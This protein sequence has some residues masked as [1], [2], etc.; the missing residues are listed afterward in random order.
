MG[1][2]TIGERALYWLR[3]RNRE[4]PTSEYREGMRRYDRSPRL[5]RVSVASWGGTVT[6][7]HA[8]QVTHELL[9][10]SDGSA[11][12]RIQL[13]FTPVLERASGEALIVQVEGEPPEIWTEVADLADSGP[14]DRHYTLD[15]VSGELR[16]GPAVRQP[17]G[18]IRV[19]GAVP[20]R[21]ANLIYER[22]RYGGGQVGNVEAN[23]LNTLKTAIPYIARVSNRQPARGGLDAESLEAAMMRTPAL[24]RSRD[25]AV[26]ESDFE[27]LARQALPGAI[28]RGKCLH[29]HPSDARTVAPGQVYVLV[30]PRI[31]RAGGYL[32]PDRLELRDADIQAL[33]AYLDARRLLT[34]RLDIRPPAYH[35]AVVKVRLRAAPGA[36]PANVEAQVLARLYGFLNPLTGGPDGDGW[37]FGRSLYV[38]D[39]YQCL[40]GIPDVQFVRGVE[41]RAALPDGEAQGDR[42]EV[43]EVTA[44][45]VIASGT[46][47]VEYV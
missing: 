29:P 37:P 43:L 21:G 28:G 18:T 2:R 13:R 19:Y 30:I 4:V 45:G 40:Q 46:H 1:S 23:V 12:Q 10:R 38:S 25:R 42:V 3:A 47:S 44:H 22:Y 20:P 34:T 8:Q 26:T 6:A 11:G 7:T 16:L 39:V 15:G 17:D 32:S 27:F 31:P 36:D 14:Y 33:T 41:L 35:W 24:L 5:R 9:G